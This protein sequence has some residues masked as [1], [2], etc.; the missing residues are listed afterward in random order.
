[1]FPKHYGA[2]LASSL[3]LGLCGLYVD[4][5]PTK[6]WALATATAAAMLSL[7]L[8]VKVFSPRTFARVRASSNPNLASKGQ[9]AVGIL[10]TGAFWLGLWGTLCQFGGS[11]FTNAVGSPHVEAISGV[12]QRAWRDPICMRYLYNP[13][14]FP[15]WGTH[16]CISHDSRVELYKPLSITLHGK[17]SSL[18]FAV[19]SYAL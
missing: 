18:G 7:P 3:V 1:V 12:V 6:M 11:I 16:Y 19:T 8:P 9:W 17:A 15:Y 14:S 4:F 2:L 10:V 13:P 5:Y